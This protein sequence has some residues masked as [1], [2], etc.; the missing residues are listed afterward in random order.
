MQS[1]LAQ[2]S[3]GS[4][5]CRVIDGLWGSSWPHTGSRADEWPNIVTKVK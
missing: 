4:M 1:D 5:F 3:H 2:N